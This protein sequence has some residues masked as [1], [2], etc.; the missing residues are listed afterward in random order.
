MRDHD[1]RYITGAGAVPG[2]VGNSPGF[3]GHG[4]VYRDRAV[5]FTYDRL[6][7]GTDTQAADGTIETKKRCTFILMFLTA[8]LENGCHLRYDERQENEKGRKYVFKKADVSFQYGDFVSGP[9][10]TA[11]DYDGGAGNF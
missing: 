11:G 7:V 6:D 8:G 2:S 4:G 3:S 9:P 10:V 5:P 1:R